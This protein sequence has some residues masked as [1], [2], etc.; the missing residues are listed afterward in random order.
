MRREMPDPLAVFK[1]LDDFDLHAGDCHFGGVAGHLHTLDLR[2]HGMTHLTVSNQLA[3]KIPVNQ[4]I[5]ADELVSTRMGVS[6]RR[7]TYQDPET[8]TICIDLTKLPVSVPPASSPCVTSRAGMSENPSPNGHSQPCRDPAQSHDA[9]QARRAI[10]PA[11]REVHAPFEKPFGP[12]TLPGRRPGP[13][14]QN[15]RTLMT[16]MMNPV[17]ARSRGIRAPQIQPLR[18]CPPAL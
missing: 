3:G 8:Q 18:E 1:G 5:I 4:G 12:Q 11:R 7:F 6:A 16:S 17:V 10:H 13:S 14:F 9:G 15:L 2:R